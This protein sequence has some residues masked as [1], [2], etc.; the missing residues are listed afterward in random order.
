MFFLMFLLSCNSD[1][2]FGP[3]CTE[4]TG[5]NASQLDKSLYKGSKENCCSRKCYSKYVGFTMNK[6]QS[7]IDEGRRKQEACIKTCKAN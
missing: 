2:S 7:E 3:E 6:K 4:A 1:S 5:S